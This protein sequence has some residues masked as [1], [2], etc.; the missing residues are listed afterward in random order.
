MKYG[1]IGYPLGHS[2]SPEIHQY[3]IQES[4]QLQEL[5]PD[6]LSTFLEQRNFDGI[7]VTIPYKQDVIPYLDEID[8]DAKAIGAINC[9]VNRQGKLY[10]YNTD[11]LG[12]KEML[13]ANHIDLTNTKVLLVGNGGVAKACKHLFEEGNV[14]YTIVNRTTNEGVIDYET[15]YAQGD[16][17]DVLVN[18]TPVGMYPNIDAMPVR[19]E[20]FQSIHTVIDLIANPLRTRL[21]QVAEN[22]GK[23]TLG[24]F[25]ML[26]RQAYEADRLFTNCEQSETAIQDCIKTIRNQKANIVLIGMPTSGKTTVGKALAIQLKREF[27]DMDQVLEERFGTSIKECFAKKGES[28]FRMEETKLAKEFIH[29][30]GKVISCGGGIVNKEENMQFLRANSIVIWLD[31][32]LDKLFGSED[33]PLSQDK[34]AILSLYQE[35][36]GLY[37]KYCDYRVENNGMIEVTIEAIQKV[38]EV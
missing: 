25:E 35:R 22:N 38:L 32:D 27:V 14:N 3:F 8:K 29:P 34:E 9:I 2:W 13:V 36:K 11:Y 37:E 20:E 21:M 5:Q 7:N 6:A 23:R 24:G 18:A 4:Y 19:L 26:V 33:R 10:G 30:E 16:Q 28:Y 17:Y 15:L 1:L 31:R 12:L